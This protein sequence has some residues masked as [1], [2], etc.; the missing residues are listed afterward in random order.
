MAFDATAFEIDPLTLTTARERLEYLR[1]FLR[2][3]PK[4]RFDMG[5]WPEPSYTRCGTAAC[6]GG[7]ADALFQPG[8]TL[9]G[10]AETSDLLGLSGLQLNALC[11]PERF[12]HGEVTP[13]E[14]ADVLTHLINT[15]EVNWAVARQPG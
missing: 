6:I 12:C 1:D 15:G 4:A 2:R 8:I 11:F 9:P 10:L 13:A 7:W 14:A 3:L 5:N